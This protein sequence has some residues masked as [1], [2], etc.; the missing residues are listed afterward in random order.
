MFSFLSKGAT[1]LALA[2]SRKW[3]SDQ[4][5][6]RKYEPSMLAVLPFVPELSVLLTV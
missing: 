3:H 2:L 4:Q 5:F 6:C 1:G